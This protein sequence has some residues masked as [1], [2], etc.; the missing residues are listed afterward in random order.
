LKNVRDRVADGIDGYAEDSSG[1]EELV[2][3]PADWPKKCCAV[4]DNASIHRCRLVQEQC[5]T[6]EASAYLVYN[7]A[8]RPDLHAT[9]LYWAHCKRLYRDEITRHFVNEWP[10]EGRNKEI[11]EGV[12]TDIKKSDI[13]KMCDLSLD[14]ISKAKPIN[15]RLADDSDE[16]AVLD[17]VDKLN[18]RMLAHFAEDMADDIGVADGSGAGN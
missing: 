3:S 8:Y 9:E 10:V 11:V 17:V 12:L 15:V 6:V 14:R 13:V 1:D 16:D 18:P 2:G 4:L 7:C 5:A